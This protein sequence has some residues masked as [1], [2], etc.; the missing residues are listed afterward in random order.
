MFATFM[1][2]VLVSR[3]FTVW[4]F[5]D[6][7][8]TQILREIKFEDSRSVKCTIFSHLEA[9]NFDLGHPVLTYTLVINVANIFFFPF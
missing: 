4:K 9:L 6:F 5:H 3:I 2:N 8:I 1:T 7:S